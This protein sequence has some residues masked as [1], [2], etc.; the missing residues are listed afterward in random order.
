LDTAWAILRRASRGK[1][2]FEADKKHL[3]H[4]LLH[5]G[6]SHRNTVL[7]IYG[8]D[9][10]LGICALFLQSLGN[11]ASWVVLLLIAAL[12]VTF[13]IRLGLATDEIDK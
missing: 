2:I 11:V 5:M 1:K 9:V 10:A 4:R 12:L 8:I 3:H 7:I 6:L 13:V